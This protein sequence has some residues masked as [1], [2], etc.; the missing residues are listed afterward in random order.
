MSD[1]FST[2]QVAMY[3]ELEAETGVSQEA[4]KS[5]YAFLSEIGLI[6]YDVE[7]EIFYERYIDEDGE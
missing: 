5:V 4:A 1:W 3:T 6:D 2:A 7:K